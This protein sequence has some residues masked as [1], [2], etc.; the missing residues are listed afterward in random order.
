MHRSVLEGGAI[1]TL[2]SL[3]SGEMGQEAFDI[4]LDKAEHGEPRCQLII[5]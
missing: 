3:R 2:L 4:V 5:G 1:G